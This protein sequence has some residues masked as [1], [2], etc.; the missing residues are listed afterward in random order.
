MKHTRINWVLNSE[1]ASCVTVSLFQQTTSDASSCLSS[2]LWHV[3]RSCY[4]LTYF[5]FFT[6]PFHHKF[7]LK[8]FCRYSWTDALSTASDSPGSQQELSKFICASSIQLMTGLPNESLL[9]TSTEGTQLNLWWYPG[10][11][12]RR[13]PAQ[14]VMI[15]R[16]PK[17]KAPSS[18]CD[19]TQAAETKTA[20]PFSR[21]HHTFSSFHVPPNTC[22][23]VCP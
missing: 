2:D 14:S 17:Q 8:Q 12:N 7:F 11:R 3:N 10:C 22:V 18:I 9:L 21:L 19:D 13:H 23:S 1:H 16:L 20:A 6:P 15:P 4:L 5:V